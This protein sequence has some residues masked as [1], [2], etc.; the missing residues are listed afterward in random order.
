MLTHSYICTDEWLTE[1]GHVL[2]PEITDRHPNIFLVLCG[3][4]REVHRRV[5]T[6]EDGRVLTAVM[7]NLQGESYYSNGYCVIMQFDPVE[8]SI[9]FTH[10]S[11]LFDDYNYYDDPSVETFVLENAY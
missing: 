3:H 2:E 1:E 6:Y 8:R 10:Y 4:A 9:S 11:P 5:K 7:Y